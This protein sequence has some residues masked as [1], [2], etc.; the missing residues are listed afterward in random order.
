MDDSEEATVMRDHDSGL[1][2]DSEDETEI[3]DSNGASMEDPAVDTGADMDFDIT[4]TSAADE[5]S[6]LYE[7]DPDDEDTI[8]RDLPTHDQPTEEPEFNLDGVE[9]DDSG[10]ETIMLDDSDLDDDEDATLRK[11]DL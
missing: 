5:L 9:D 6:D 2:D 4:G 3:R 1:D 8:I 10:D 7:P 11:D